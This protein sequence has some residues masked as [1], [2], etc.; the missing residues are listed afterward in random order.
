MSNENKQLAV[1]EENS[2]EILTGK[3]VKETENFIIKQNADGKFQ[4]KA[5]FQNYSSVT[6]VTREDRIWLAN[7]LDG[8]EDSGN[9]LK[10]HVGAQIEVA[11]VITRQY[12]RIN[13]D[14]GEIE[15]GVLI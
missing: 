9:G 7:L 11:D 13:E 4:R 12:D 10:E 6:A 1:Q 14:T 8:D 2:I 15:Y 3:V 5:K